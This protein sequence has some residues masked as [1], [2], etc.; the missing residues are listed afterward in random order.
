MNTSAW[1]AL[2]KRSGVECRFH[3][4]RHT[5]ATKMAEADVPEST[6]LAIMGHMSRAMLEKYSHIRMAAKRKAVKSSE[7][8]QVGPRLVSTP[9]TKGRQ[10]TDDSLQRR[11][12]HLSFP[13]SPKLRGDL[14][15]RGKH[16]WPPM[17]ADSRR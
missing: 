16:Y 1:E 5:A 17:N 14:G 7:M 8:P 2:L 6:M 10:S 12:G 13:G 3:D 4:L 9:M 11:R 15:S